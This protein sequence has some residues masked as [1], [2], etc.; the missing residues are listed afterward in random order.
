M[1][2]CENREYNIWDY[3]LVWSAYMENK[4]KMHSLE[5]ATCRLLGM[6]LPH[7]YNAYLGNRL[8]LLKIYEIWMIEEV[9]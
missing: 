5:F 3:I 7:H 4:K 9:S 2:Q 6:K 8:L 1:I